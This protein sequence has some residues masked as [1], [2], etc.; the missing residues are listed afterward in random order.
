MKKFL[1]GAI[2]G[3]IAS[4]LVTLYL[5]RKMAF[6]EDYEPEEYE[7]PSTEPE[8]TSPKARP[9]TT[10]SPL[11]DKK[12]DIKEY[13]E[14]I[15]S[16]GYD[17]NAK[18]L[19]T[20]GHPDDPPQNDKEFEYIKPS[21]YGEREEDGYLTSEYTFYADGIVTD[22]NDDPVENPLDLLGESW[23]KHMGE[24]EDDMAYVRNHRLRLDFSIEDSDMDYGSAE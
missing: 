4:A 13:V 6:R 7:D 22:E 21:E 5:D 10:P 24:Y 3:G 14:S 2:V 16:N 9:S 8:E 15:H 20:T 12:M 23:Y 11:M 1:L 19:G 17:Y 18:Y